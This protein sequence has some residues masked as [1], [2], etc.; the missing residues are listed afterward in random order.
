MGSWWRCAGEGMGWR[1][2]DV[3]IVMILWVKPIPGLRMW[4]VSVLR[5]SISLEFE[6]VEEISPSR[7]VEDSTSTIWRPTDGLVSN[8]RAAGALETVGD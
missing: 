4:S 8:A 5:N 6:V 2:L 1:A 3:S 7:V